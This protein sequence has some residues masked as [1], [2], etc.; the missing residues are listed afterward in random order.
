MPNEPNLSSDR[1]HIEQ[2]EISA[3][4]GVLEEERAM[5]QRLTVATPS[6]AAENACGVSLGRLLSRASKG[7][8][9]CV[10]TLS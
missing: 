7:E 9:V 1:I 3:H 4:I 2:L 6:A 5:P 8:M 10:G